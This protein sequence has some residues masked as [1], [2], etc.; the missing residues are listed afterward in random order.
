MR[1]K[2]KFQS[3]LQDTE[4]TSSSSIGLNSLKRGSPTRRKR[5]S[6]IP[7]PY[8][9]EPSSVFSDTRDDF[10]DDHHSTPISESP[11][12]RGSHRLYGRS[13][14]QSRLYEAYRQI[15][16]ATP[17]SKPSVHLALISG[18]A[19]CGKT[20]LAMSMKQRVIQDGGFFV[21]GKF[22]MMQ[23]PELYSAYVTA[24]SD[25]VQQII[26]K[27]PETVDLMKQSIQN[28]VHIE[29]RMLTAI[30]PD[31]ELILGH[32]HKEYLKEFREGSDEVS[33]FKFV[34]RMFVRAVSSLEH[35]IVFLL[36]DLHYADDA[37]LE[38]LNTLVT[39]CNNDGVL[40][41]GTYR[42]NRV[43]SEWIKNHFTTNESV[44]LT[45]I[46]LQ[47]LPSR[48]V[49]E[50]VAEFF[51]VIDLVDIQPLTGIIYRL[52]QGNVF[53]VREFLRYLQVEGLLLFDEKGME[54]I[55]DE[56]KIFKRI[57]FRSPVELM[58]IRISALSKGIREVLE[59][60]ASIG[61]VVDEK[62]LNRISPRPVFEHLRA[63]VSRGFLIYDEIND[64]YQFAH[65]IIQEAAYKMIPHHE[66]EAFHLAIGREL[67]K[68]FEDIDDLESHLFVILGQI[69]EGVDLIPSQGERYD[70]AALCLRAG[71]LAIGS[72]SFQTASEYLLL[73]VS[74]C[75]KACWE[76]EYEL[77]LELYNA[78]LKVESSIS[79][80]ENVET[81]ASEIFRN[82]RWLPDAIRAHSIQV[83]SLGSRGHL[84][85][86]IE[87]GLAVLHALGE[88][89]PSKITSNTIVSA[90][91]RTK[92]LLK[93]KSNEEILRMPV[94]SNGQKIAAMQMLNH[95]F[96]YAYV[97]APSLAPLLATRIVQISLEN[98]LC[99]IS[100]IGF[101]TF[102]MLLCANVDEINDG[103]RCGELALQIYQK[104]DDKAWLGR[105]SAWF[106]GSVYLWRKP[107]R[108]IFDRIKSAHRAALET[109]D[110]E[111]AMMNANIYCWE[112]FDVS[113]LTKLERIVAGFSNRMEA[114]GQESV[115]MM[116]KPLWQTIHNMMG[117]SFGDPTV[118][119][120]EVMDQ[121]YTI[122]YARENNK[123]LL[124]WIHFYRMFLAYIL[125]DF[126]LA[127]VHASVCRVAEYSHFGSS[128]RVLFVFYDGLI[129]LARSKRDRARL[130]TMKRSIRMF[131]TWAKS[132]PANFL[133]KLYF[134]EA[135][136]AATT[137]D[138][139]RAHSMYTSAISHSREGGYMVQHALANERAGKFFLKRGDS[140]MARSY[141]KEAIQIYEQWG[142]T[143]KLLQLKSEVSG[144]L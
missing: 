111:F 10:D 5:G 27:G 61:C 28:A 37:S 131:K 143:A 116:I 112:S 135:E 102:A 40:F 103:F 110:I 114:Y 122:Q 51:A 60:S 134:L 139:D 44:H 55:W 125:G 71:E 54:W 90:V 67:W 108:G 57:D 124:L 11:S 17:G 3:I 69:R 93:A 13:T 15:W 47:H 26:R 96:L 95:L 138:F 81:L 98:G 16:N 80:F 133:G 106:Y 53:F 64:T 140:V 75:D 46:P 42:D 126:E 56:R 32:Q 77:S 45:E 49:D 7:I 136:L 119:T 87:R 120:G 25:L 30:I 22:D 83:Y 66:R 105:I 74:L 89:F 31:L 113:S 6:S 86:A 59:V 52:T 128:D 29:Q 35:P 50:M 129:S 34:V 117:K 115:F 72:S 97:A 62:L 79:N 63:A 41:I 109:G 127:E 101:V 94:A 65:D 130:Q 88:K 76:T 70:V 38:L 91:K 100:S 73:G 14:D 78:A 2:V 85:K 99:D 104:F 92:T 23:S 141:L 9:E 43:T 144:V 142:G 36:D 1:R 118:L 21:R 121:E 123:T 48:S 20:A 24:F 12:F 68:S 84:V 33:C 107:V 137:G 18:T 4:D 82:A 19:G 132:C 8:H 58:M 39:D